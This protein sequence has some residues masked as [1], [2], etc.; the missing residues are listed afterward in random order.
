ML[1]EP[2]RR[3]GGREGEGGRGRE[4]EE[5]EGGKGGREREGETE[6]GLIASTL[7]PPPSANLAGS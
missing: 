2:V 7:S 1:T 5:G 4:G 3:E 6:E